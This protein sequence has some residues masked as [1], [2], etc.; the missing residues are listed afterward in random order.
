LNYI[1]WL[2]DL[3]DTTSKA[4]DDEYDPEK[5][6]LGLDMYVSYLLLGSKYTEFE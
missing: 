2:Q 4:G 6:V 3:L 1:L 5:E